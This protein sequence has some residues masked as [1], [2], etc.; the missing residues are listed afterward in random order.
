[1]QDTLA[2]SLPLAVISRRMEKSVKKMESGF[3]SFRR[4]PAGNMKSAEPPTVPMEVRWVALSLIP[5]DGK[6]CPGRRLAA[7]SLPGQGRCL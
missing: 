2:P 7:P 1:M 5:A 3:T 6:P 4:V